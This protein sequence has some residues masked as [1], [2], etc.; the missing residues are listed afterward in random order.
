M[1]ESG[2]VDRW[3]TTTGVGLGLGLAVAVAALAGIILVLRR[4]GGIG[5][6][7]TELELE[8]IL[9]DL[10]RLLGSVKLPDKVLLRFGS[11][12]QDVPDAYFDQFNMLYLELE[13]CPDTKP[14]RFDYWD[15]NLAVGLE[16]DGEKRF[17]I[18]IVMSFSQLYQIG[19]G[20]EAQWRTE[21]DPG[22]DTVAP[23]PPTHRL[24]P[25]DKVP[26]LKDPALPKTEQPA[27]ANEKPPSK[28]AP[29]PAAPA[30]PA[31]SQSPD[32][33]NKSPS[34]KASSPKAASAAKGRDAGPASPAKPTSPTSKAGRRTEP[35]SAA[36]PDKAALNQKSAATLV[37]GRSKEEEEKE[38]PLSV[39]KSVA[40]E[41]P[42][43]ELSTAREPVSST[44]APPAA[45]AVP[46]PT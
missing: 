41:E 31:A 7:W 17:D 37:S 21:A 35:R 3:R 38:A 39:A 10:N 27:S 46:P 14:L 9:L 1:A 26:V 42:A 20:R 18:A 45:A 40:S 5:V 25:K 2:E 12:E 6:W 15:W 4:V 23:A 11:R 8:D 24:L 34:P 28:P 43:V 16:E 19:L 29:D 32:A 30:S 36:G 13:R 33:A 44:P 22:Y